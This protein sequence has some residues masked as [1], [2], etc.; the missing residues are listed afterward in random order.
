MLPAMGGVSDCTA[1]W[2]SHQLNY[3]IGN[4]QTTNEFEHQIPQQCPK[5]TNPGLTEEFTGTGPPGLFQE[6]PQTDIVG[7]L[8]LT[9][10]CLLVYHPQGSSV[11]TLPSRHFTPSMYYNAF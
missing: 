7:N 6:N 2:L 4:V 8:E 1:A 9:K 10:A 3:C 5:G 11:W